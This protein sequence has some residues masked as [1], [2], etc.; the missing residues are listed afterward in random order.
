MTYSCTCKIGEFIFDIEYDGDED[1]FWIESITL[2][3]KNCDA[4]INNVV[5]DKCYE[6]AS[7]D[8]WEYYSERRTCRACDAYDY[9]SDR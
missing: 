3:G 2:D 6:A 5:E 1:D 9:L 7:D 4:I 8:F